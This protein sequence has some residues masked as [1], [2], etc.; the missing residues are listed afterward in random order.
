MT[1]ALYVFLVMVVP[2]KI[3]FS[4][5]IVKRKRRGSILTLSGEPPNSE[6]R[7]VG[8]NSPPLYSKVCNHF[9]KLT[10]W[11]PPGLYHD[12]MSLKFLVNTAKGTMR[13]C[14]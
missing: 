7:V 12:W 6:R 11:K 8:V 3:T 9:G 4:I 5:A 13:R 10:S 2:T 1:P 14:C